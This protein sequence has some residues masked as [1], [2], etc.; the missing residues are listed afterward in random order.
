MQN[1]L[2]ETNSAILKPESETELGIIVKLMKEHQAIKLDILGHTDNV[3]N[4]KE[5]QQLSEQRAIAVKNYLTQQGVSQNRLSAKGFGESK[6]ISDNAT[7]QGR[8][9]NRRTEFVVQ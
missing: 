5:N 2:F 8:A 3:G 4:E 9:N 7:P 1:I 6:P